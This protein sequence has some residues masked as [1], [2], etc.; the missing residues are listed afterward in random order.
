MRHATAVLLT[1]AAAA[2]G[3]C[4][5]HD[6]YQ[7]PSHSTTPSS[8]AT[9]TA[10]TSATTTSTAAVG[11]H[12]GPTIPP[13]PKLPASAASGAPQAALA[14]F[15]R[16]YVNWSAAQLAQ[17]GRQLAALSI[18]QAHAQALR[19]ASRAGDLEQYHVTNTGTIVA[20]APG[21]GA[22]RGRWVIVTNEL[23]SGSGPYL[24]LPATSHV[25]WATLAHQPHGYVI[26]GWYPAS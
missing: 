10:T 22:E 9:T 25:T 21:Q 3:G 6:P 26:S 2:L 14:R 4:G 17:R 7:S 16:L 20:I 12:D 23:T 1:V 13:A 11:E 19:L 24:G 5:I 8:T 18:G 15:A